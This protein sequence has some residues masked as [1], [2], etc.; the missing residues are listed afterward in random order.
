MLALVI[1][2]AAGELEVKE[3][4][5]AKD[6]LKDI[7]RFTDKEDRGKTIEATKN[8]LDCFNTD[9]PSIDIGLTLEQRKSIHLEKNKFKVTE[10]T[11][12][13]LPLGYN[14]NCIKSDQTLKGSVHIY[15]GVEGNVTLGEYS[16]GWM[17]RA[18]RC[19]IGNQTNHNLT[20]E[21][22]TSEKDLTQLEEDAQDGLIDHAVLQGSVQKALQRGPVNLVIGDYHDDN[23]PLLKVAAIITIQTRKGLDGYEQMAIFGDIQDCQMCNTSELRK[24]LKL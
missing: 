12:F 17:A 21:I 22:F 20:K 6:K 11:F 16:N 24:Y 23:G 7:Q 3:F 18:N 1:G 13:E 8:L 4:E 15:T 9:A 2:H 14:S 10:R 5:C 19:V